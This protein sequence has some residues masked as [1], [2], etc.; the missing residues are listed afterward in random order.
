MI[1]EQKQDKNEKSRMSVHLSV[2][3]LSL[4]A[5]ELILRC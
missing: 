5:A 3:G 2:F 1:T 4:T